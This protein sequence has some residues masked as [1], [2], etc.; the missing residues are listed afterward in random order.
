M[1]DLTATVIT[2][3][4]EENI[5]DC[6]ES[7]SWVPNIIVLDSGSTDRTVEIAREFTEH[8]QVTDWPGHVEQKNRAIALAS[9]DWIISIDADERISAELREEIMEHLESEPTVPGFSMPRR[10]WHLGQWI[11]HG[12]WYPDRKVRVFN[13]NK[14]HWAG[15]N[16]HDRISINGTPLK[17]K[18]DL[19]HYSFRNLHHHIEGMDFFTGISGKEMDLRGRKSPML[20]MLIRAPWRFFRMLVLQKGYRDG[21][22]GFILAGL[23]MIYVFLKY[24][25][26]WERR[27][28]RKRGLDPNLQPR[29][30]RG[31][32]WK[33]PRTRPSTLFESESNG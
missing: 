27:Q 3:N 19:L 33:P 31:S 22:A 21:F 28:L 5:R 15:V 29:H 25:C 7:L 4:E 17:L 13:R 26:L 2:Y 8:V 16:P 12:G 24:A 11:R 18:G 1:I 23:G 32:E 9:T 30:H 10:T 20:G 6:L 14:A